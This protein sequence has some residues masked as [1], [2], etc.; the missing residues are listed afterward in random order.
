[1]SDDKFIIPIDAIE[2]DFSDFLNLQNNFRIIFSGPFGIGKT[3]FLDKFFTARSDQYYP[4]FLCPVNYSLLSNED[5]FK[6]IKYDILYQL[7]QDK[8][9]GFDEVFDF[10]KLDYAKS[11]FSENQFLILFNLMKNLPKIKQV[12]PIAEMIEKLLKK[13]KEGW[14]EI[15]DNSELS[16][17]RD[18][19]SET[20]TNFLLEF[21][22]V[23]QLI[24]DQL[25]QLV[26]K[27]RKENAIQKVLVIDDLDRLDP[28][29]I[30]RLFN[31]FSAHFDQ[32]NYRIAEN[33]EKLPENKFGF[34]KIIFVCDIENIRKIFAH[35]YGEGVDFSGYIDKFYSKQIFYLLHKD[36]F[37][38]NIQKYI[39]L[40]F[41]NMKLFKVDV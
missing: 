38:K 17:L 35:K 21:D 8:D 20:E 36:A 9:F 28:E 24:A 15:N 11:F 10:T 39:D 32:V 37:Q 33:G 30:F 34:D 12:V 3:Y 25:D 5:V 26:E 4:V 6:L 31:V 27:K 2:K 40:Q 23:S 7:I 13:F 22:D 16:I 19:Q 1:M 29:H 41:Q 18:F 14:K